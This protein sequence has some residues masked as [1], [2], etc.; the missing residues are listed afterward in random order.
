M[1]IPEPGA[2]FSEAVKKKARR[3]AAFKCCM[4][5]VQPGDDIHH[6]LPREAGGTND[7]DNAA[8][9]CAQCHRNYGTR[10][11]MRTRIREVRDFWYEMVETRYSSA[12]LDALERIERNMVTKADL[13]E[14]KDLVSR[15][16]YSLES[17]PLSSTQAAAMNVASTMIN[18]MTANTAYTTAVTS[19]GAS[20]IC[21]SCH[22]WIMGQ[23]R[24]AVCP[25]CNAPL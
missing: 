12:N 22:R 5:H 2:E 18:S 1:A 11:E 13:S 7:I 14:F 15:F 4:C 23:P 21:P 16:M 20:F 8:F 17:G 24:P 10:P 9:L 25:N 19:A 6:I 3:L